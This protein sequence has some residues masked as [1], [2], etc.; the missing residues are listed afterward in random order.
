MIVITGGTGKLG[1]QIVESVLTRVP[2]T[3]VGVSVRDA[4]QAQDLA[5]RG[6]RVREATFADPAGLAYAFAGATQ[7]LIVSVDKLGE[8]A[9]GLHRAAIDAAVA[10]GARRVLYTSHAGASP[11]SL[12][13]ACR[14]H[15]ATEDA[16]AASGVAYTALR[17]GFYAATVGQFLGR[18]LG[19]GEIALPADAP[20]SW[21][22]YADLAEAAA[23]ILVDEG[24]FDGPT[25]PLTGARAYTYD[26][27]AALATQLTGRPFTRTTVPDD[28]FRR[29]LVSHGVPA[30]AADLMLGIFAASRAGEFGAVDPAL[31]GLIGRE[32][33]GLADILRPTLTAP[34]SAA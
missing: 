18:S 5:D 27:V 28:Q 25:P 2:A 11:A 14:D 8:E 29:Q 33:R 26:D 31:A 7:V 32:P 20:V 24:R 17:N 21:T 19:S 13:Q 16:L 12:F 34:A 3:A 9:V 22:D 15:A 23:A 1:R 30:A 4:G 6:V 10:A